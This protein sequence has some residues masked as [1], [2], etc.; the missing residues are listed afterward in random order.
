MAQ[1]EDL[2]KDKSATLAQ[3]A[4]AWLMAQGKDIIPIP[5]AKSRKHLE[6][7]FRAIEIELTPEDLT[8]LDEIMPP[9]AASGMRLTSEQISRVNI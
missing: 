7:N 5:G 9:G 3:L 2:A 4:L 1:L 8:R 6:E